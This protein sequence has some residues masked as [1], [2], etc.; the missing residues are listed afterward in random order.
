MT[1]DNL[2]GNVILIYIATT[3]YHSKNKK[4]ILRRKNGDH[5]LNTSISVSTRSMDFRP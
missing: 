3:I 2:T 1:I 4:E 5:R